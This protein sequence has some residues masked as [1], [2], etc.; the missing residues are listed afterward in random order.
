MTESRLETIGS[1]VELTGPLDT[2]AARVRTL[3]WDY[4][5]ETV[6]LR[7]AHIAFALDQYLSGA[8]SDVD[9]ERWANLIEGRE[10][11]SFEPRHE[12]WLDEVIFQLA[13]PGMTVALDA[14]LAAKL[15]A[16]AAR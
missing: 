3:E 5:G 10:D 12:D 16:E 15:I 6:I 2:V 11:I 9:V 13:N 8:L 14:E 1:L 7:R 4:E